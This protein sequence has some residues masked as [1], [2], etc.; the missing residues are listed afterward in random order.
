[1]SRA[2]RNPL[3]ENFLD[4]T[5]EVFQPRCEQPLTHDDAREIVRNLTGFFRVLMEWDRKERAKRAD[6][7]APAASADEP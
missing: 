4:Y 6:A 3:D 5:V 7:E 2:E 1:M